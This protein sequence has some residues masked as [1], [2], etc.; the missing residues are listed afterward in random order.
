MI[1]RI[2]N[3][4]VFFC[5]T[6][7][8]VNGQI[9]KVETPKFYEFQPLGMNELPNPSEQSK[10]LISVSGFDSSF[11]I[12][13]NAIAPSQINF[14]THQQLLTETNQEKTPPKVKYTFPDHSSEPEAEYYLQ[15]FEEISQMLD[16]TRALDLKRAVFLTEN[17]YLGNNLSYDWYAAD[18]SNNAEIVKYF[19]TQSGYDLENPTARKWALQ[20]FM[21]DTIQLKDQR[22]DISF[23]H[24]PLM[25]DFND[26]WGNRDWTN[27]FVTK[28]MKNGKGQCHSM[29][30]MYLILAEELDIEAWLAY[31][32]SHSYIKLKDSRGNMMNYET[33][34]GYYTTDV[35]VQSSGYIKS[36]ALRSGIY[37]DT[38]SK[39][40]LIAAC[41]ADLAKGYVVKYGFDSF[42]I[43]CLD[44]SLLHNP[45]NINALQLKADYQTEL[46]IYVLS[47]IGNPPLKQ[48]PT[49][50]QAYALLLKMQ[51]VYRQI[52]ELGYEPIPEQIYSL[53][54]KSIET[55]KNMAP[56]EPIRP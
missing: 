54:L 7:A 13:K 49:H 34:N 31:S 27:Q 21:S 14:D 17:A 53:W 19:I 15:A 35:W 20:K 25:Y 41:L 56:Q 50:P 44:L 32:P 28:L 55:Q 40:A 51:E 3:I 30:L 26:P 42:A 24:I 8:S 37:M 6:L 4:V 16:S 39:Q 47:Q 22:G 52:D 18:I 12:N 38:L 45:K 2:I 33:T 43:K 36:E 5:F 48:L 10:H 46:L 9:S 23:T 1:M 29:P 11:V